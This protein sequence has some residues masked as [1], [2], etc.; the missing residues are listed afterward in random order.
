[1][2]QPSSSSL[3][4]E[5][6]SLE[7][8]EVERIASQ[9]SCDNLADVGVQFGNDDADDSV[10]F[11]DN[12]DDDPENDG[13]GIG[14][15]GWVDGQWHDPLDPHPIAPRECRSRSEFDPDYILNPIQLM[16]TRD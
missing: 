8:D 7:I 14:H 4:R 11:G 6:A 16:A 13:P 12:D 9:M 10:Q 1:M 2:D 5:D 3:H 15:G